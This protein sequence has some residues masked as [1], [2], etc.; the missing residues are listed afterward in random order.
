[1][2]NCVAVYLRKKVF[3]NRSRNVPTTYNK[4][5]I[6]INIYYRLNYISI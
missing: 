1:M 2:P 5:E 6:S 4:T 3:K